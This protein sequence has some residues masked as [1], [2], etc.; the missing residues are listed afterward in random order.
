M[1]TEETS[2][3]PLPIVSP[4]FHRIV[5]IT[6]SSTKEE[7]R[8]W[9]IR[10]MG[11]DKVPYTGKGQ[12][13]GVIDTGCDINH[14]DLEGQVEADNFIRGCQESPAW[15]DSCGHGTFV[16]SEI[17][18]KNDGNG[19]VGAAYDAKA[20]SARVIYGDSRDCRRGSVEEDLA[21]AVDACVDRDCGVISMSIGGPGRSNVFAKALRNA[22]SKGVI[23]VAAAGNER[24]EGSPYKSYPAAYE[25]VVSVAAANKDDLPAWFSTMGKG[26]NKL[27]Q[28]EVA[29]AALEYY[30]GAAPGRNTYCRMI[31]TSMATPLVAAVAL[32]WREARVKA[33]TLPTGA[34]VL[35]EFRK[36]LRKVVNDTNRNGWDPELGF[37]VLLLEDGEL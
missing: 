33:G 5:E 6:T 24:L 10:H 4:D 30:W 27:E 16:A 14:S 35:D 2:R 13:V 36:W 21:K 26:K 31:G 9:A 29:V 28:P 34:A 18:A 15:R 7:F 19:I 22:V 37:G 8:D 23:P 11:L 3:I 1:T 20:F 32:L 12:K 17:V 25:C